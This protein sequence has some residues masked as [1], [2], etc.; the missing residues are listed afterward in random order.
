M[1]FRETR[2]DLACTSLPF[3]G[4]TIA[5]VYFFFQSQDTHPSS[6]LLFK[7][8]WR[9]LDILGTAVV[10]VGIACLL[11]ALQWGGS[12]YAW[13]NWRL[14]LLLILFGGL[15]I[16]F[17]VIQII[18][19]ERGTVP[20]RIIKKRSVASSA[21]FVFTA[22]A[23]MNVMEYYLPIYFQ[24]IKD[25]TALQSGIKILP[26]I[27]GVVIFSLVAGFGVARTGYYTPFML[28]GSVI[29]SIGIGLV[30]TWHVSTPTAIWIGFQ[31]LVGA[32]GGLGIQQ[33]H[34]AAQRVLADED[35]PTGAVIL[36]FAQILG[37]TLFISV[38]ENVFENRLVAELRL[39]APGF[40]ASVLTSTGVTTLRSVVQAGDLQ[41]VL[42][43]YN[44]ALMQ[45]FYVAVAL[46]V[47][48]FVGAAGT[49]WLSVKKDHESG[50]EESIGL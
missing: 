44:E 24:A 29:L 5:V 34:T 36:I 31:I 27:L 40:D 23:A 4:V 50:D 47:L 32:G 43:A 38:A 35:V 12:R 22:G 39:V 37:G 42:L 14:V 9:Q 6:R 2:T 41:N 15:T 19:Q 46:A 30:T 10:I 8:K 48:S 1:V 7:D 33:A 17:V 28:A 13:S 20:P 26:A 21:W 49:E 11:L 18:R 16:A 25:T 3:G 45:T